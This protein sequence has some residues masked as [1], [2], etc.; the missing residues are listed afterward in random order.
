MTEQTYRQSRKDRLG[1]VICD[2]L[3]DDELDARHC[4]EDILSEVQIWS[5]YH[6]EHYEKCMALKA[7]LMG[8]RTPDLVGNS[9]VDADLAKKWGIPKRY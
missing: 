8:Y 7:L 9:Y 6:K 5:D 3:S 4:Y 2:Y 1:D